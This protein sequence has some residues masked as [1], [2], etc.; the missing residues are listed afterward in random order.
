MNYKTWLLI[1]PEGPDPR[2]KEIAGQFGDVDR[3][4][5]A[6]RPAAGLELVHGEAR[7]YVRSEN[8]FFSLC[9]DGLTVF[10]GLPLSVIRA[11]DGTVFHSGVVYY[12]LRF[13]APEA[14]RRADPYCYRFLR[15][16]RLEAGL[17][18]DISQ[19]KPRIIIVA[20]ESAIPQHARLFL[21][22]EL[23]E[24]SR[25]AVGTLFS[26]N[27]RSLASLNGTLLPPVPNLANDDYFHVERLDL[28][29]EIGQLFD[30][31]SV[32]G[33]KG[34]VRNEIT[35]QWPAAVLL[36]R[37]MDHVLIR[38]FLIDGGHLCLSY[39]NGSHA[40]VVLNIAQG[41]DI[42][43]YRGWMILEQ[44]GDQRGADF[45]LV[46]G[47][48]RGDVL[49]MCPR[50]RLVR[51]EKRVRWHVTAPNQSGTVDLEPRGNWH[52]LERLCAGLP[53]LRLRQRF[54][55]EVLIPSTT[56]AGVNSHL[57]TEMFIQTCWR[58]PS[59]D[60]GVPWRFATDLLLTAELSTK[61]VSVFERFENRIGVSGVK[62]EHGVVT[63]VHEGGLS[64]AEITELRLLAPLD[65]IFTL[66]DVAR[67][68]VSTR[69]DETFC[70]HDSYEDPK[71]GR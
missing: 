63:V 26:H 17:T 61:R 57:A 53:D 20:D 9:R 62:E 59:P 29:R 54:E 58:H 70:L 55:R 42:A 30:S 12:S 6:V 4:M 33:A 25:E 44:L 5:L 11:L 45:E 46:A 60:I 48:L 37:L 21:K 71:Y 35:T 31:A 56:R 1:P 34:A 68:N 15:F 3:M 14:N 2:L 41:S 40:D 52:N 32:D 66:E 38:P 27:A 18:E 28:R 51:S 13:M 65:T 7:L 23:L 49:S 43:R 10:S 47:A 16:E 19:G 67:L 64:E 50:L 8:E 39:I 69:L 22:P 36:N 24:F